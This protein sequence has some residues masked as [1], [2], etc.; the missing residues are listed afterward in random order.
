MTL[1]NGFD[2]GHGTR[3]LLEIIN[4]KQ[5]RYVFKYDILRRVVEETG[6]DG[7]TWGFQ[8]DS[9]GRRI[10]KLTPTGDVITFRHDP[11]G[12][13]GRTDAARRECDNL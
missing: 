12:E 5:E 1:R 8:Y 3:E 9:A 7:Q 11:L 6:F 13:V 10:T 4:G 2:L